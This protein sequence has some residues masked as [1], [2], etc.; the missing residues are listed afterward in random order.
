M[1]R[2]VIVRKFH[3]HA[4]KQSYTCTYRTYTS[5]FSKKAS[6]LI[7]NINKINEGRG[8]GLERKKQMHLTVIFDMCGLIFYLRILC[9]N[10][11]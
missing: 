4:M 1:Y 6:I 10:W 7:W 11:I 9:T 3:H 8:G 2:V 5:R